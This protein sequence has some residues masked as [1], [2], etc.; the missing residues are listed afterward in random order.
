MSD[1]VIPNL[2]TFLVIDDCPSILD[3][4]KINLEQYGLKSEVLLA[5]DVACAKDQ[6]KIQERKNKLVEFII[7][8]WNMP[9]ESGL[10]MLKFIRG[11]Q[12]YSKIPFIILTTVSEKENIIEAIQYNV[13][14]YIIKPWKP[15]E[16][17]KKINEVYNIN[18]K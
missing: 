6:L 18:K 3:A 10:D 1:L 17:I 5:K 4:V 13:S 15:S 16:L 8:D 2:T 14:D 12:N 7:C 9:G 11:S